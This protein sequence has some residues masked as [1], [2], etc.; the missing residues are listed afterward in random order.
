MSL[1]RHPDTVDRSGAYATQVRDLETRAFPWW[2]DWELGADDAAWTTVLFNA[3]WGSAIGSGARLRTRIKHDTVYL[4]GYCYSTGGHPQTLATIAD[5]RH[6]P[7]EEQHCVMRAASGGVG[8]ADVAVPVT[9]GI[10]GVIVA[11]TVPPYTL[12]YFPAFAWPLQGVGE[13]A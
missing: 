3:P 11:D 9:I 6:Y 2:E 5:P 12:Y 10:N 1:A 7:D 13:P 4:D 8:P